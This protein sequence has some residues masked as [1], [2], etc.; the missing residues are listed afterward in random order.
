MINKL[1]NYNIV[2]PS[3]E[4]KLKNSCNKQFDPVTQD[5]QSEVYKIPHVNEKGNIKCYILV[6]SLLSENG[7]RRRA[8]DLVV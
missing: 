5:D 4:P 7:S 2:E 1:F 6:E 3:R 8:L